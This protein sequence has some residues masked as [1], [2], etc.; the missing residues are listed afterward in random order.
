MIR[1]YK[2]CCQ[3]HAKTNRIQYLFCRI[4]KVL[5]HQQIPVMAQTK[6]KGR[7][8]YRTIN[9]IFLFSPCSKKHILF[10]F[11]TKSAFLR[12]NTNIIT[13]VNTSLNNMEI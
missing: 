5:S 11:L 4:C 13:N 10:S 7:H 8:N 9:S 1:L 12:N 3:K 2:K 6:S